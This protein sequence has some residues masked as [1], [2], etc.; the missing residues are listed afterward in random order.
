[1]TLF[2][3]ITESAVALGVIGPPE[4]GITRLAQQIAVAA[5]D[6]GF[7]G[8][9]LEEPDPGALENFP[10]RLPPT[11]RLLHL[12]V[13]D[14][15]FATAGRTAGARIDALAGRLADRGVRLALTLHDLPQPSADPELTKR[16]IGD[17]RTMVRSSA[18]AAVS[19]DHERGLLFDAL[20]GTGSTG[21]GHS[22]IEVIPLPIDRA[23][24]AAGNAPAV[25]HGSPTVGIFGYLYPG[26]GHREVLAELAGMEAGLTV[27]A[28]GQPSAR[29]EDLLTELEMV[30]G[31]S[32]MAFRCTG[33]VPDAQVPAHLRGIT[34]AVAPHTQVSA[35]G[36]INSWLEAGRRPLVPA[37]RYAE[38]LDRRMPGAV[39]MYRPGELRQCV[40][41]A[42][43]DPELTLLPRHLVVGPGIAEVAREYLGWLRRLVAAG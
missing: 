42:L 32:G 29:H 18:G 7:R 22:S 26:K 21:V 19:S 1:M 27:V 28:I 38:E 14:W 3:P 17:Y 2:D 5:T 16:R 34:V 43:D 12:Q 15:L 23:P 39:W 36:S 9:V 20:A 30:A 25:D 40:Q 24:A 35:S 13:N 33:Y 4:H 8:V 31:C 10:G 11:V 6:S 37:G 41:L